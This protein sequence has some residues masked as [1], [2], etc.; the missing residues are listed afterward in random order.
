MKIKEVAAQ[1]LEDTDAYLS[2]IDQKAYSTQLDL[3]FGAS[4]GQHTRHFIEFFQCLLDQLDQPDRV[5]DYARRLR[6]LQ[7]ETRPEAA[8]DAIRNLTAQIRNLKESVP[9]HLACGDHLPGEETASVP[10]N[11]ERELIYNIEHT[12]HHL[13]I[14]KIGLAAVSPQIE[15]PPHFGIAPSTVQYKQGICAQ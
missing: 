3:L 2:E 10:S 8:K 5:I 4:I 12:I 14:I 6:D 9:C 11:L 1:I 13:A 15:L 7:L